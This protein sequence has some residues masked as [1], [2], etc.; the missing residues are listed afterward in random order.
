[1]RKY[2]YTDVM[3]RTK[4]AAKDNGDKKA[5]TLLVFV[6]DRSGSMNAC[7]A[8]TVSGFN[9][10]LSQQQEEKAD[11]AFMTLVKFSTEMSGGGWDAALETT[12]SATPIGDVGKLGSTENAYYPNG[13]TPLLD[14]VGTTIVATDAVAA[15]Y[16]H[17][18]FVIQTDGEEN[19]SKEYNRDSLF[20]MVTQR[21]EQGWDFIF[22]GADIDAYGAAQS[23]NIPIDNT[24]PYAAGASHAAFASMANSVSSYRRSGGATRGVVGDASQVTWTSEGTNGKK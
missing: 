17:I 11:L 7:L 5:R 22:M 12:Y 18:L 21:R 15:N 9:E 6:L 2:T 3:T 16:D 4:K 1:M 10:F 19:S 14:A 8:Q 20:K 23:L 24:M 13:G